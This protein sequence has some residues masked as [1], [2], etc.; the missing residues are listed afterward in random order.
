M[1]RNKKIYEKSQCENGR[2]PRKDQKGES[3]EYDKI[4]RTKKIKNEPSGALNEIEGCGANSRSDA[5][6]KDR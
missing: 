3:Y 2:G 5:G 4:L 6:K 1:K